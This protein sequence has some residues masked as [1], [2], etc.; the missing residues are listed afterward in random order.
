MSDTII[1]T[2]QGI[3]RIQ[4][5]R[6]GKKN[7]LTPAMYNAISAALRSANADPAIRVIYITGSGDSFCAGNDLASFL[8]EPESPAAGD[9]IKAIAEAEKPIVA[10][11]NGVAVGVGATILLHCDLV[12]AADT[13]RFRFPFVDLGIVPEAASTYL[14]PRMLGYSRAAELLL[15]GE[16]FTADTARE[17][18]LA[19][20]V[21]AAQALEEL[22]WSK[23]R[24]L[25]A[26]PP[27]ALRQARM[28]LRR[29][30]AQTVRETMALEMAVIGERLVSEEARGI[31]AAFFERRGEG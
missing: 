4:L 29:G 30:M 24:M 19:N 21:V 8:A 26:K 27:E 9:F 5:N 2:D 18:G 13:A 11:V 3:R 23:A 1:T 14:L 22:A 16:L 28:L 31:M 20:Q 25:A 10:A 7:A 6:P 15:L 12:Y 17:I